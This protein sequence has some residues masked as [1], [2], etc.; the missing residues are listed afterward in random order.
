MNPRL[1]PPFFPLLLLLPI[2]SFHVWL[3]EYGVCYGNPRHVQFWSLLP[4]NF[5]IFFFYFPLPI[6]F[7]FISASTVGM[8]LFLLPSLSRFH[9]SCLPPAFARFMCVRESIGGGTV[10]GDTV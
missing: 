10:M 8:V 7:L 5:V 1:A 3:H 6:S 2:S 9:S 4:L